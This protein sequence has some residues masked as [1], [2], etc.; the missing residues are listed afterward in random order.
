MNK[1]E[2]QGIKNLLKQQR[3]ALVKIKLTISFMEYE[4]IEALEALK[5][6]PND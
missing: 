2:R 6:E 5:G 4:L 1:E 3:E